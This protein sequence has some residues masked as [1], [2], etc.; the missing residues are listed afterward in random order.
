MSTNGK[1]PIDE[2]LEA[3][4]QSVELLAGSTRD[5]RAVAEA[6]LERQK[7]QHERDVQFM[8]LIADVLRQWAEK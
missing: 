5:L 4:A 7:E 8:R 1:A 6:T 3:L 2:R